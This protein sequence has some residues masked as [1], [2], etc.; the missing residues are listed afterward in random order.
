MICFCLVL[1]TARESTGM[2][3]WPSEE[4]GD[5]TG[6]ADNS[7]HEWTIEA[8][9]SILCGCNGRSSHRSRGRLEVR[10]RRLLSAVLIHP[11]GSR[12]RSPRL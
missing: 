12:I 11:G 3:P 7:L 5:G 4:D 6:F 8:F 2:T 1:I 10:E 9:R